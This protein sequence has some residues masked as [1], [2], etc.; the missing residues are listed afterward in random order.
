MS[1]KVRYDGSR[2]P[3]REEDAKALADF[4][5]PSSET[6]PGYIYNR[7]LGDLIVDVLVGR[8]LIEGQTGHSED[9]E[10]F[11]HAVLR[12]VA[13]EIRVANY[14]LAVGGG[15]SIDDHAGDEITTAHVCEY[16]AGL[17][18]RVESGA[19][20]AS[21][22]RDARWGH[23]CFGGGEERLAQDRAALHAPETNGAKESS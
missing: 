13:L 9:Y 4:T 23:P 14:A 2:Y 17:A 11:E 12:R 22:L 18:R 16:L 19:E 3:N 5:D 20:L 1:M 6:G 10:S 8:D 15:V 21:R 7:S